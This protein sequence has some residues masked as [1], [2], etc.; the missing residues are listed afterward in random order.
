[1]K[2][3]KINETPETIVN[4]INEELDNVDLL[5]ND[6]SQ[7]IMDIEELGDVDEDKAEEVL[8]YLFEAHYDLENLVY[9]LEIEWEDPSN[10][11]IYGKILEIIKPMYEQIDDIKNNFLDF[12]K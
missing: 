12:F 9:S 1:M 6:A 8:H 4:S 3:S 10:K 5:H 11:E 7:N 2:K